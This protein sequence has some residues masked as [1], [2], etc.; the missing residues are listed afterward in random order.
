MGG[1]SDP[2]SDGSGNGV[3][4]RPASYDDGLSEK[5]QWEDANNQSQLIDRFSWHALLL[6]IFQRMHASHPHMKMEIGLLQ[7]KAQK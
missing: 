1:D 7:W 4:G 2:A 5:Q 3:S 6:K